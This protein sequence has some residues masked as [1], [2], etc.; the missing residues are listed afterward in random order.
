M[1]AGFADA[2]VPMALLRA[3]AFN[4]RWATL[5]P[6]VIALTAADP[7]FAVAPPIRAALAEYAASGVYPYGPAEGLPDFREACAGHLTRRGAPTSA[8]HLLAV[9]S[10][11]AGMLHVSRAVLRPG[12]EV[13]VFDPV[14]FLFA[15]AAEAAGAHVVRLPV[16]PATGRFDPEALARCITP[17]TRLF[18]LCNPHNPLGRVW[19]PAELGHI[20][21][22][23][24]RHDL[25]VLSDEVWADIVYPPTPF[26]A[27]AGLAPEVAARTFTVGGFSKSHG[28]AGLRI[29]YVAAPS[30]AAFERLVAAS[31]CRTTMTG[32]ST[33]SQVA[34]VAAITAGGPHLAAFLAHLGRMRDL[35]VARLRAMP[36]VRVRAPEGTFV[37]FPDVSALGVPAEPLVAHLLDRHRVAVV[38]GSTRFFGPGAAG[39]LRLVFSTAEGLL[40]EGLDRLAEGLAADLSP[41][42]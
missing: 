42:R 9:D 29:G 18:G 14:D 2:D 33:L 7:D 10:A 25:H 31:G 12:D 36:G 32:A 35:A 24:L 20:A 38:P 5:P 27:F 22:V 28:L 39:H 40:R 15:S 37:L 41:W 3:R 17:R 6:D 1:S 16:D 21:E 23:V 4:H 13:V 8:A 11:A 26:T 34:A 19:T 30:S